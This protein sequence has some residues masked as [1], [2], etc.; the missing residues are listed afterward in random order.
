MA[1]FRNLI[2]LD[3]RRS[4]ECAPKVIACFLGAHCAA[5]SEFAQRFWRACPADLRK[6]SDAIV[7]GTLIFDEGTME[8]TP[9]H[10]WVVGVASLLWNSMGAFDFLATTMRFESYLAAFTPEQLEFFT[11]FPAWTVSAWAIAVWAAVLASIFILMRRAWAVLAMQ[12][13]FAAMLIVT[14]QNYVLSDITMADIMGPEAAIFAGVIFIVTALLLWY[15]MVQR[16][17]GRLG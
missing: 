16:A 14:F 1:S 3:Y 6:S 13:S 8:K 12:V 17:A 11:S 7:S 15:V 2:C 9:W 5:I 4:P 10:I